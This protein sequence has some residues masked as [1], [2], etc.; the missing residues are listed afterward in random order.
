MTTLCHLH[1]TGP[2]ATITLN[3]PEQ[4]NALSIELLQDAHTCLDTLASRIQSDNTNPDAVRVVV[5]QGEGKSFCAGMD[6]RQVMG[7]A[8][9][10]ITLLGSLAEL[11]LKIR[12]LPAVVVAKVRGAAIGGGCGLT[13]TADL[14]ITHNDSKMG[15]PE[16]DLGVCPAVVAPWLVRKIGPG[17]ARA[18]LL[19][20]G[21]ITGLQAHHIGI[22]DITVPTESELDNA[23]DE[24]T[25]RLATG[26]PAAI[27]ATKSLLNQLDNSLDESIAK[28]A[29]ELSAKVL[30]TPD[31]Q[32]RLTER[33][34]QRG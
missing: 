29:A 22:A 4:R 2:I 13:C 24:L 14:C 25:A 30:A 34:A 26:G 11:A 19:A 17:K 31:A 9:A 6:L 8:S 21:L 33:F 3:R 10:P 1:I 18:V 23:T 27:A 12:R 15:F 7:D 16:V 5:I 28:Q 32:R 20:G